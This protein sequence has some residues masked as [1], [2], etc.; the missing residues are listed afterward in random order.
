MHQSPTPEHEAAWARFLDET[1]E[2]GRPVYIGPFGDGP[3]LADELLALILIDQKKA[4]CSLARWY[5]G[6][7]LNLPKA[8]DLSLILDGRGRPRCVIRT[9]QVEVRPFNTADAQFA[10]DE[11]EGDRS[12]DWWRKAH[13][14]YF[15]REA[16]REGFVFD[17]SMD[18]VFEHFERVWTPS[19]DPSGA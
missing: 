5:G 2:T 8:G 11:G 18:A 10:W 7:G 4:T 14:D 15:R 17:E 12:L 13:L 19:P 6:Q 9:T 1:G 16:A 3:D